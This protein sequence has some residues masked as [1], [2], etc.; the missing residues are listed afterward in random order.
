MIREKQT[1]M[2]IPVLELPSADLQIDTRE[3][4]IWH[5]NLQ[6]SP[7]RFQEMEAL[8]SDEE[9]KRAERFHF[10]I[11][12]VRFTVARATLRQ[13]LAKYLSVAPSEIQFGYG[14]NGKP[15]LASPN[16]LSI[17]FN[18]SHSEDAV[19]IAVC[20]DAAV[21]IDVENIKPNREILWIAKRFFSKHEYTVLQSLEKSERLKGFYN[22]WTRK[23]A[24]VKA[25]GSGLYMP[26]DS[27]AVTLKP[28]ESARILWMKGETDVT[29]KWSLFSWQPTVEFTAALAVKKPNML[30]RWMQSLPPGENNV[31]WS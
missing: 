5:G 20:R 25:V 30:V 16:P 12:R 31:I 29:E 22:C 26:L 6:V 11:H 19:V 8:L 15:S 3:V 1:Q 17:E 4:H 7:I 13:I 28:D 9:R 14:I 23:E 10:D 21:G 2:T 27:F 18:L 24:F